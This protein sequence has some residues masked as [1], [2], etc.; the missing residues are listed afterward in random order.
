MRIEQIDK[1]MLVN[2]H[3]S[4]DVEWFDALDAER[5]SLHGVYFEEE[6]KRWTRL[7]SSVAAAT[8]KGVEYLAHYTAGGRLCF[9]TDSPYLAVHCKVNGQGKG[10]SGAASFDCYIDGE[11]RRIFQ[12]IPIDEPIKLLSQISC[13]DDGKVHQMV[14]HLPSY[15]EIED[16]LIGV[17]SGSV[18]QAAN[19]YEDTLPILYYGSSITQGA[20]ASRPG[21]S[22]QNYICRE[23]MIDYINL[24]FSGS[25][26]GEPAIREY[27]A[28]LEC[29][30]FVMDLDHNL[31]T[32]QELKAVHEP[33]YRA[34]RATHPTTPV[35][36]ISRPDDYDG[37]QL[38][39]EMRDVILENYEKALSE[40]DKNL[41]FIDGET[42][43]GH[44][45]RQDC[46][47][48]GVHPNDLGF[49]R[50]YRTLCPLIKKILNK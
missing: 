39:L 29:S 32:P 6:T 44:E 35:I 13:R 42:I 25:A 14:L 8:N 27:L 16:L 10:W 20:F 50:F 40:G 26:K 19:P 45:N 34:F 9:K 1:N 12:A 28:S 24:G 2:K 23:T 11:F 41:Y 3:I 48:D 15:A 22:Y 33:M 37:V 4:S 17:K 36:F 18:L 31:A 38:R 47:L 49:Y 46:S 21:L 7:P 30:I 43:F 5:F